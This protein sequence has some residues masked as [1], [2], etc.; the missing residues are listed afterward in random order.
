MNEVKIKGFYELTLDELYEILKLR[1]RVFSVEQRIVYEDPDELDKKA[2]HVFLK[3]GDSMAAYLRLL[4]AG[5]GAE[6]VMIGR[7]LSVR[8]GKGYGGEVLESAVAAAKELL[9]AKRIY[10]A[11]QLHASGFYEEHGF[12]KVS[13]E[14]IHAGIPHVDMIRDI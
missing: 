7:V 13:E 4:P 5:V 11:S 3:D 14:Y 6:D 10:I 8:R 2:Y 9:D 1:C 12:H